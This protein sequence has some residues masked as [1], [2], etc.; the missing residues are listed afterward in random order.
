MEERVA[1]FALTGSTFWTSA[2]GVAA[3]QA[4]VEESGAPVMLVLRL[5][6]AERKIAEV[7]T[8]VT[9]SK[10]EGSIFDVDALKTPS[11]AMLLD[12]R[13]IAT[14]LARRSHQDRRALSRPA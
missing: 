2:Q 7:E 6:V 5:K 10:A 8:Q 14:Q 1:R 11:G 4:I 3:T 12:S 9:R 13:P